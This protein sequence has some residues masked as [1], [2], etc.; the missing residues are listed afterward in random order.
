MSW[1]AGCV[2]RV[3]NTCWLE[4][5]MVQAKRNEAISRMTDGRINVS[6]RP[7]RCRARDRH[8]GRQS[9]FQLRT[10]RHGRHL[11]D[12]YGRTGRAGKKGT[13]ISLVEAHDHLLLG[14]M[15]A[16]LKSRFKS[17]RHR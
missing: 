11:S 14:K 16:I 3:S 5:E 4:G 8:R 10:C 17:P 7:R 13:A 9:R 15:A 1:R 2:K 12:T 6:N